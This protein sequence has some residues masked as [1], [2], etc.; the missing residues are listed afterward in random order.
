VFDT[1]LQYCYNMVM[2]R[3]AEHSSPYTLMELF[4]LGVVARGNL[5]SLY[6]LQRTVGLEPGGIRPALRRLEKE[7]LLVRSREAKRRR[8]LIEATEKG[9]Q[10]LEQ[11]WAGCIQLYADAESVLRAAG[12]AV[13]MGRHQFAGTYLDGMAKEYEHKAG[14]EKANAAQ[15]HS[16]NPLH[17]YGFMRALWQTRRHQATAAVFRDLAPELA[18]LGPL[19]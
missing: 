6:E 4:L 5:R 17:F 13:L 1:G 16:S 14:V 7:E 19:K 11:H 8:R 12:L 10:A 3:R 18:S 9:R 2:T 15:A